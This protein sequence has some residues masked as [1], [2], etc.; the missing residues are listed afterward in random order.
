[1]DF[2]SHLCLCFLELPKSYTKNTV[3]M[4]LSR[5][6]DDAVRSLKLKSRKTDSL[7]EKRKAEFSATSRAN[8]DRGG[9][10]VDI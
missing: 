7:L 10:M 6:C 2:V 9:D 1:M 3:T 8:L 4:S 5:L